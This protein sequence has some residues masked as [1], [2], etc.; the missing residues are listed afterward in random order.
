MLRKSR[1]YQ[2]EAFFFSIRVTSFTAQ[3]LSVSGT[4][5]DLFFFFFALEG[6]KAITK[7][8]PDLMTSPDIFQRMEVVKTDRKCN[9]NVVLF[10]RCTVGHESELG[11]SHESCH[12][13]DVGH[14]CS[15]LKLDSTDGSRA[16][17][18]S[19]PNYQNCPMCSHVEEPLDRIR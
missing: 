15:A 16:H 10:Y 5:A 14:L 19:E 3:R 7:T 4:A 6:S 11:E 8:E 2:K 13:D 1:V 18:L 12:T 9:V 17:E